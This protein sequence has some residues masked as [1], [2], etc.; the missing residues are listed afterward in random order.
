MNDA[1]LIGMWRR[2]RYIEYSFVKDGHTYVWHTKK[3]IRNDLKTY[4][5]YTI[6]YR[7]KKHTK[8]ISYID[9]VKIK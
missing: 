2:S 1:L 9:Y 7:L 8:S 6:K 4:C 5:K 3:D